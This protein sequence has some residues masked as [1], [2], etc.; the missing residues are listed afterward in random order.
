MAAKATQLKTLKN[1]LTSCSRDLQDQVEK[2]GLLRKKKK[3]LGGAD[4]CKLG[5]AA[6]IGSTAVSE[7]DQVLL[8]A[9]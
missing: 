3:P 5:E 7:L 2:R 4:L 9:K 1:T 8:G 6:G